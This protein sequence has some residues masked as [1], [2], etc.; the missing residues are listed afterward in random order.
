MDERQ[1]TRGGENQTLLTGK[2]SRLWTN[3]LSSC[4][5]CSDHQRL[6]VT[7]TDGSSAPAV[8]E[9]LEMQLQRR[10]ERLDIKDTTET[11]R[12]RTTLFDL[13]FPLQSL[14]PYHS[15]KRPERGRGGGSIFSSLLCPP[16]LLCITAVVQHPQKNALTQQDLI[17]GP[18]GSRHRGIIST[19]TATAA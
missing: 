18:P 11:C 19:I 14:P 3:H 5:F 6:A 15:N 17:M 16:V 7:L 4:R 8:L 13:P 10:K 9:L 12:T 2:E 1:D